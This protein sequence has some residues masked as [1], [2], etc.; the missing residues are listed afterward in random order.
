MTRTQV[1]QR[2]MVVLLAV[3]AVAIPVIWVTR[4]MRPTAQKTVAFIQAHPLHSRSAAERLRTVEELADLLNRLDFDERQKVQFDDPMRTYYAEM[5]EAERAQFWNLTLRPG[6]H[7]TVDAFNRMAP[8]GRRRL[9]NV[10]VAEL[11][12]LRD[13]PADLNQTLSD[14]NVDRIVQEGVRSYFTDADARSKLE[15][16]PVLER[17]QN[18]LQ[19]AR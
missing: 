16:Q 4:A 9:L 14:K 12:R 5:S 10:A 2:G 1:W 8:E 3:W 6:M 17:V 19:M 13:S 7:Q 15:M 18:I 11:D